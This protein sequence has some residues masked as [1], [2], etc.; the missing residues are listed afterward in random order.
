MKANVIPLRQPAPAPEP[1]SDEAVAAACSS[2][3]PAAVAELF[4]RF[5]SA[6]V[7]F[8]GRLLQSQEDIE[9]SLQTTFFEVS[10]GRAHYDGR[11]SVKTWILAIAAN[12]AR[13]Q[14]RSTTRQQRL[15]VALQLEPDGGGPSAPDAR[16]GAR[17]QI[18]LARRVL[19]GLSVDRRVAFVLCALE[20]LSAKEAAVALGSTETAIW[21]RVSEARKAI[22][23]AVGRIEP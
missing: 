22:L 13:N 5:H 23:A 19:D 18:E 9:D 6:I 2:G 10:R 11:A 15:R 17:R 1:L 3:D 16:V 14:L 8:L 7:R 4:D 12:V 21:K 20:G